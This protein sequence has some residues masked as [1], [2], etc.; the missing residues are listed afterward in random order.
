LKNKRSCG[1]FQKQLRYINV[2][3]GCRSQPEPPH[4]RPW[5]MVLKLPMTTPRVTVKRGFVRGKCNFLPTFRYINFNQPSPASPSFNNFTRFNKVFPYV[6]LIK[7]YSFYKVFNLY[8]FYR[9]I[10]I[11]L[12]S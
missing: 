1:S 12:R 2:Q 9:H 11:V 8:V 3:S 4:R 6:L 7:A 10:Y 5:L